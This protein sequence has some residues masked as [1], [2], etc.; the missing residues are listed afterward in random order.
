MLAL[1]SPI[2]LFFLGFSGS[3]SRRALWVLLFLCVI[4][5]TG[6]GASFTGPQPGQSSTYNVT[7]TASGAS[8]PTHTQTFV[9]TMASAQ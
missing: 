4:A 5:L 3:R 6:C 7:V 1:V 2:P 8:A 9:L